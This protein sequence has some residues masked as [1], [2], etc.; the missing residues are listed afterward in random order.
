MI[1]YL[2]LFFALTGTAIALPGT[3]TV[4]SDDIVNGDVSAADIGANQVTSPD[5]AN[6]QVGQADLAPDSVGQQ[7][8]L[9]DSVRGV[10]IDDDSVASV[11]VLSNSLTGG[12]IASDTI[13]GDELAPGSVGADELRTPHEH[14]SSVTDISDVTSHDGSYGF[15][16]AT[17][18]CGA[19][20]ELLSV[21]I[22]WLDDN[23]HV[24]R[25]YSGTPTISHGNPSSATVEA[26]FDGGG[27]AGNP[28]QFQAVAVCIF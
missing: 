3:N 4:F 17:V 16:V 14:F 19:G 13:G 15:S 8:I 22:S 1:G 23:G 21:A 5:I 7:E 10:E 11:D 9:D 27:G 18:T 28:G 26:N 12:D 25:N 20:E 24:E 6:A 2:A